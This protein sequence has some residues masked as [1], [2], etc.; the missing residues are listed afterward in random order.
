MPPKTTSTV[1]E[2]IGIGGVSIIIKEGLKMFQ[3]VDLTLYL[4]NGDK[5]IRCRGSVVWV[6]K[7]I[8]SRKK[9][10]FD[11]GIEFENINEHD[12]ARIVK[13]VEDK[14]PDQT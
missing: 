5:P 10:S 2:N 3:D 12:R 7:R 4:E 13:I 1:T 6:V 14:I 9:K 8:D 11:I